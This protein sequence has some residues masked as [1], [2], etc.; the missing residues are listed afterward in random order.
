MPPNAC[1]VA[2]EPVQT[3]EETGVTETCDGV[4]VE[5]PITKSNEE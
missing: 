5:H 1:K 2:L 4:I 3:V